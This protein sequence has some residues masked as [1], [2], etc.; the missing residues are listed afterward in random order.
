MNGEFSQIDKGRYIQIIV[1][2]FELFIYLFVG[3]TER[4]Y[5]WLITRRTWELNVS[6][7]AIGTNV[8]SVF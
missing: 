4:E 6:A 2:L 8:E 5:V 1:L 7:C 3:S